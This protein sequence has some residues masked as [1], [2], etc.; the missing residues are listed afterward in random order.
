MSRAV[1]IDKHIILLHGLS[2]LHF[3]DAFQFDYMK[4]AFYGSDKN[5]VGFLSK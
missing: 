3:I 2:Y 5:S 1:K 4:G